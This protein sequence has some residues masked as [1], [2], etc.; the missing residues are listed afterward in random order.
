MTDPT[1][2]TRIVISL[3]SGKASPRNL[4]ASVA[5]KIIVNEFAIERVD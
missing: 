3:Y 2:I 4:Q 1:M 5:L